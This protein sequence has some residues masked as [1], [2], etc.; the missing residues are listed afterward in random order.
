MRSTL[1]LLAT[2]SDL[3]IDVATAAR[4]AGYL[5]APGRHHELGIDALTRTQARVALVH[6]MHDAAGA[7]EFDALAKRLG[8]QVFLFARR[9]ASADERASVVTASARATAPLLEYD[10]P[11]ALVQ[12]MD[13][14]RVDS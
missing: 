8:T 9:T 10:D 14:R 7:A 3:L 5:V 13:Q 11:A 12:D 6:V 4:E 2:D 1:L